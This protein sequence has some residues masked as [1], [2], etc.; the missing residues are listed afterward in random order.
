MKNKGLIDAENRDGRIKK[1]QNAIFPSG[2]EGEG[3]SVVV[4]DLMSN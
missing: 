1:I 4:V 3:G 2:G